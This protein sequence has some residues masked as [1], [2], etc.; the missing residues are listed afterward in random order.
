MTRTRWVPLALL[1]LA[2][3]DGQDE[4]GGD[5]DRAATSAESEEAIPYIEAPG[6]GSAGAPVGFQSLDAAQAIPD[7]I[8]TAAPDSMQRVMLIR[9]GDARIEVDELEPAVDALNALATRV[10]GYVT[11][12]SVQTGE[13]RTREAMLTMRVPVARFDEAIEALEPLGDVEAVNVGSEDVGEAYADMEVRLANGRRLEQR[14]LELLTT[15]T[16]SLEDV[17][18]VERELARVRQEIESFEGRMRYLRNRVDMSTLSVNVHE[19]EPLF[20]PGPGGGNIVMRSFRE[21]GRNFVGLIAGFIASLGVLIP[22]GLLL[23]L[24]WWLWRRRRR[25]RAGAA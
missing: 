24:G 19:A 20:S 18:A 16:G 10:G 7:P 15:R 21:A 25:A 3:C 23:W 14:L 4:A 17:L 22:V 13:D 2:G 1:V 12:V 5:Y 6:R 8:P 9:T 11:N